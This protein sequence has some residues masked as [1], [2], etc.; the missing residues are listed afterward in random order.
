MHL[1]S[2]DLKDDVTG[3]EAGFGGRRVLQHLSG[4]RARAL[5]WRARL[6]NVRPDPSVTGLTE[7]D[8]VASE[9]FRRFNWQRITCIMLEVIKQ[10]ADNFAF[11]I[12]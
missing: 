8:V 7:A 3:L 2:P 6:L 12:Q 5:D 9:F 10:D 1:S 4:H 11:Q